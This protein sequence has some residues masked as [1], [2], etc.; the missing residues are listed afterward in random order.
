M[1]GGHIAAMCFIDSVSRYIPG[2]LG[3]ET[4]TE[5]ESF[6][7][8]LLEHEQYTRPQEFMGLTVPDILLSGHHANIIKYQQERSLA[9]TKQKRPDLMQ[10]EKKS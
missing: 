5:D 10:N 9:L 4:S 1:T 8:G 7:N 2:V 6:E 3:N